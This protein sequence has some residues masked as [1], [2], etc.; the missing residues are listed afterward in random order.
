[1]LNIKNFIGCLLLV[2]SF[3]PSLVYGED[4]Q[5]LKQQYARPSEVPF[6]EENPYSKEKANLGKMLFFDPRLSV[7]N[8]IS[9]ATCHNPSFAWEDA[10]PTSIGADN[11]HLHRHTPTIL[12]LA[13]SDKLYWDGRARSLQIQAFGPLQTKEEMGESSEALVAELKLI[14]GYKRLFEDVFPDEGIS[15]ENIGYAI[16]TYERTI[17]SAEAPFDLWISGDEGAISAAAKR[18]FK[19]FTGKAGCSNCHSGWNFT[20]WGMYDVGM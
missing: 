10:L 8:N 14:E 16:A 3:A 15:F 20:D 18:G 6:P 17:V 9:C 2:G 4:M 1:M 11:T 19:L 12:N 5:A 13:W 7:N